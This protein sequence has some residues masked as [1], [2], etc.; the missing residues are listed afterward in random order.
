MKTIKNTLKIEVERW[1]DPGGPEPNGAGSPVASHNFV[2]GVSGEV[3]VELEAE[4]WKAI[5]DYA[6]VDMTDSKMVE[7]WAADNPGEIQHNEP[8]L[9]VSKWTVDDVTG[10]RVTLSVDEFEADCPGPPER[11][12]DPMEEIERREARERSWSV[13]LEEE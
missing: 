11:E 1:S 5:N 7:A 10:D 3:V 6:D 9:T 4:D 2:S 13:P 8:G 12:Y